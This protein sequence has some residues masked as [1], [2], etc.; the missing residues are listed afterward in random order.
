MK[1]RTS[2]KP[3]SYFSERNF[4]TVFSTSQ[5]KTSFKIPF[6]SKSSKKENS[7]KT[8]IGRL[9]TAC[10]DYFLLILIIVDRKKNNFFATKLMLIKNVRKIYSSEYSLLLMRWSREVPVTVDCYVNVD[11]DS[12]SS[13]AKVLHQYQDSQ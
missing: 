10:L 5:E 4:K 11:F 6:V 12:V 9:S 2:T 13:V 7:C 1:R 3:I 8:V